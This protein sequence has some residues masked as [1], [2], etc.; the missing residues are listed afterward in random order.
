MALNLIVCSPY[1]IV[2]Q[3][4]VDTKMKCVSDKIRT[5]RETRNYTQE[6]VASKLGISQN[7][8]SKIELGYTRIT[9][10][11]LCHIALILEVDMFRFLEFS[12]PVL[13]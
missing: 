1:L 12:E 2:M 7:A 8:Y 13:S 5:H 4:I 3:A 11:R 10:E 6:Y 9:V